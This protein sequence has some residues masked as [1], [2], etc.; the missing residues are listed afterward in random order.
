MPIFEGT[1]STSISE[2]GKGGKE[3]TKSTF[4]DE[5]ARK[6]IPHP[7]ASEARIAIAKA[8]LCK[9][10]LNVGPKVLRCQCI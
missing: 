3:G 8:Q 5:E 6:K 4:V 2:E 10:S 9:A 1:K 7:V